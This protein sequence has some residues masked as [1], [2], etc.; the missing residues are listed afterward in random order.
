MKTRS[1]IAL[2]TLAILL[3]IV[4]A[5][6]MSGDDNSAEV[7]PV[8]EGSAQAPGSGVKIGNTQ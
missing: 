1:I 2:A 4:I 7:R 3:I 6:N 5:M 8:A